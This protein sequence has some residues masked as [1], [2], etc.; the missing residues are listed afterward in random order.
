MTGH[1][2]LPGWYPVC[3]LA[4]LERRPQRVMLAGYTLQAA[5]DASGAPFLARADTH[6]AWPCRADGGF[7][8]AALR[9]AADS[10]EPEPRLIKAPCRQLHMEGEVQARLADLAENI[11][12][13]THTSV[14]HEGYLR[15]ASG[16]REVEAHIESGDGWVSATYGAGAAPSG[17]GAR[18]IGAH[19]Y[20]ICDT[21][22]AP[23]V[24]EVTYTDRRHTIFAARFRLTPST[25]TRT[26]VAASIAVPGTGPVTL[27]KLAALRL[28]FLRIFE[29][30]RDILELMAQNQFAPGAQRRMYAPQ[31]LLRPSIDAILDGRPPLPGPARILLKV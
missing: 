7:L 19:R 25:D 27:L 29:E 31:D 26:Y 28:F 23:S 13:T 21:F 12:D 15:R 11:L 24:A 16:G 1:A 4:R 22:R 6:A 3:R 2:P 17:W 20:T 9:A 30:D 18:L 14:V 8:F 5:R 10:F